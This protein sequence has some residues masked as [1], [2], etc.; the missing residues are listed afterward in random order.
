MLFCLKSQ[1]L[2]RACCVLNSG[3]GAGD[4]A[5]NETKAPSLRLTVVVHEDS[6]QTEKQMQQDNFREPGL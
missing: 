1:N 4:T 5:V 3:L 6:Q 2:L